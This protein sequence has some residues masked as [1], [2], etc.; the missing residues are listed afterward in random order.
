[1]YQSSRCPALR[2]DVLAVRAALAALSSLA[3][4]SAH[5]ADTTV[6]DLALPLSSYAVGIGV[7]GASPAKAREYN[8][9]RDKGA[10]VV[11]EF[12]LY[13]G[14]TYDS[15]DATRWRAR[16]RDLGTESESFSAQYG[17]QGLYRLDVSF[18]QLLH[19]ISDSYETPYQG[20]GTNTF[21]LPSTWRVPLVPVLS[22]T[23]P[24]AR[25]LSPNVSGA[26]GLVAGTVRT[27]TAAQL[28]TSSA[29]QNADL[30]L[31][32][33]TN[34]STLRTNLG[35]GG[36]YQIN[37]QWDLKASFVHEDKNGLLPMSTITAASGGDI[38]TTLP[39]LINQSHD[40]LNA[41]VTYVDRQSTFN[42]AYYGSIFSNHVDSL[43]WQNWALP[44]SSQT[45]TT[46]PSNQ[47]HQLTLN[48]SYALTS[49][50]KFSGALAYG[51]GTQNDA[52]QNNPGMA[53]ALPESSAHATLIT[54]SLNL[55]LLSRPTKDLS[56]TGAYKFD[57][58]DNHTPVQT[59]YFYDVGV[60]ASAT[61]P[62][63]TTALPLG[64]NININANRPYSKKVN[65]VDLD[66]DYALGHGQAIRVGGQYQKTDRWC[67]GTWIACADADSAIDNTVR[68]EWRLNPIDQFSA[69]VSVAGSH[70]TVNY[71][72]D[73][74]LALVPAANLSPTGAPGGATA[75][76]T[77]TALGLTGYGPISGLNPLPTPGSAQA[78]FF[79]NNNAIPNALY[80]NNNRI[81]ELPGMR[82]YDMADRNRGAERS[83][84]TWN[85]TESVTLQ[86]GLDVTNDTYWNSVYGLKSAKS[87]ALNFEGDL[88]ADESLNLALFYT[89]EDQR[90]TSA[91]NS[92][93]ANAAAGATVGGFTAVG[94]G[95]AAT[96]NAR[97][98]AYKIDPCLNWGTDMHDRV[99]TVGIHAIR[100]NLLGGRLSLSGG[101]V[102]TH[103]RTDIAVSGGN[104]LNNP[105]AVAGAPAG[106][107]AAFYVPATALPAVTTETAELH[108]GGR[109]AL[110]NQSAVHVG[111]RFQH[112]S[113]SDYAYEGYQPGN[114]AGALPT[115]QQS[116][117][118]NVSTIAVAY[119]YSFR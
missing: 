97:N 21:T 56:L 13:G 26:N 11:G 104:Y 74:W 20:G 31:F 111:Y 101:F 7:T 6:E 108:F 70:R 5:A 72:E 62:F 106:T 47:F 87:S 34:L 18:S 103:A 49:D 8:G 54:E 37:R 67:N 78:F 32:N 27:P 90:S 25:G 10:F 80:G 61:S 88:A 22:G 68:A 17:V 113:T 112:M 16:A 69:R 58:R 94:G 48:G 75:Y 45:I 66:A 95:C 29:I 105:L 38:A 53:A 86:A 40:Q 36:T 52:L 51:R 73:S 41:G 65:Q 118:F 50:T 116:P 92:Y 81:S 109:Y 4:G 82:R 24:N 35:L 98:T 91:G 99:D 1:M 19:N 9:L 28:A 85:A 77:L 42:V 64:S 15:G 102:Y 43:T 96:L 23:S 114:L 46:A 3:V 71:N 115:Y 12:D 83:L 59:F 14:G 55:K 39:T 84:L 2:A 110:S 57:E 76:S 117:N 93:A 30:P 63:S 100:K 89:H 44:S 60:A 107:L 33:Q 79:P 119:V